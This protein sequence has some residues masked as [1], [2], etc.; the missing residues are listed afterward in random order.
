MQIAVIVAAGKGLRMQTGTKKQYLELDGI[1][2][3]V[4]T[5][6]VFDRHPGTRAVVLVVPEPD[7]R[8][9]QDL[10]APY[11]LQK[12]V[13]LT[14]GGTERQDSVENGI[15]LARRL[16]QD[17]HHTFAMVHD[18]VRPFVSHHIIDA[19]TE[20][21]FK[22]GAAIPAVKVSDTI[23]LAGENGCIE[24]TLDRSRLYR[25]QTPQV[26][27]LDLGLLAFAHAR[28]TGFKGT[29]EA[30]ILAHAGIPVGIVDGSEFNIKLTCPQ[31]LVMARF[32]LAGT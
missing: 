17:P 31:D 29:D 9:C 14:P 27:R 12:A 32:I 28:D 22:T 5:L 26:F 2:V 3:L 20:A 10:I 8:F 18:G 11:T 4:R 25:A 24:K 21:A 15:T 7:L 30:A 23:K 19:C 6:Q 13:H 16:C 1:P